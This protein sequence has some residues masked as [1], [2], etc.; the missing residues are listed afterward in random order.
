MRQLL[1]F[2]VRMTF[3]SIFIRDGLRGPLIV[4]DPNNPYGSMITGG[5]VCKSRNL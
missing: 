2:S 5:E 4:E 1:L 3:G